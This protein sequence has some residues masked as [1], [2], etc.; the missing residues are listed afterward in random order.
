MKNYIFFFLIA[1]ICGCSG[2]TDEALEEVDPIQETDID[3]PIIKSITEKY[4]DGRFQ[5]AFMVK[6]FNPS[7]NITSEL[8]ISGVD[9][10]KSI[11]RV[12]EGEVVSREYIIRGNDTTT[13]IVYESLEDG[14]RKKVTSYHE[15]TV[16]DIGNLYYD[17]LGNEYANSW[18]NSGMEID[19]NSYW[20][21]EKGNMIKWHAY[22]SGETTTFEYDDYGNITKRRVSL[23][24]EYAN[25]HISNLSNPL[26]QEYKIE[27]ILNEYGAW[28]EYTTYLISEPYENGKPK[29]DAQGSRTIVYY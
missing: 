8:I 15:G 12:Y 28:I 20:Y 1:L 4:L 23:R 16:S 3:K 5:N 11:I 17:E 21:N 26:E 18:W 10:L 14:K 24:P 27:N 2:P 13:C 19:T 9:T 22:F 7:G 6:L 29:I 25:S